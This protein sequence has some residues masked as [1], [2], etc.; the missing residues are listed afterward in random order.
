MK[1]R[2]RYL[3]AASLSLF[4]DRL[5]PRAACRD[6]HIGALALVAPQTGG[7]VKSAKFCRLPFVLPATLLARALARYTSF[8][9]PVITPPNA[10]WNV[11]FRQAARGAILLR[12]AQV[13]G[14]CC[15]TSRRLIQRYAT[16][17]ILGDPSNIVKPT[18]RHGNLTAERRH[19]RG[20]QAAAEHSSAVSGSRRSAKERYYYYGNPSATRSLSTGVIPMAAI[21]RP[22]D[23]SSTTGEHQ[24]AV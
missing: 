3:N 7:C 13:R 24:Q 18:A 4:A 21:A 1:I 8:P 5:Q 22:S 17:T 10:A 16:P 19:I 14:S 11:S 6:N 12:Q 15:R 23:G 20:R 9:D 2:I